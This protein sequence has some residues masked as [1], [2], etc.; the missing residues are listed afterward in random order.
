[1]TANE[2]VL[3]TDK[4]QKQRKLWVNQALKW[5]PKKLVVSGIL[6][7]GTRYQGIGICY[8]TTVQN[9]QFHFIC[10]FPNPQKDQVSRNWNTLHNH[11]S[12]QPVSLHL[13][14]SQPPEGASS[15]LGRKGN[16]CP[17]SIVGR[18]SKVP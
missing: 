7:P 1:M 8:T 4:S 13:Q 6:G 12:E 17:I 2:S 18:H 15:R 10:S 5:K 16:N 14:F 9:N 3:Y 11:C